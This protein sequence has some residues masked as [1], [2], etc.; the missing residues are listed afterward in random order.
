MLRNPFTPAEIASAPDDFFG[1]TN[2]LSEAKRSLAIGSVSIQ[3]QIGIGKSSLLARTRLEMEGYNSDHTAT[4][5]VAVAHKDI[6]SADDLARAILEDIIEIDERQTKA[7]L[8]IGSLFEIGSSDIYRNFVAGRH[9][10]V[11]LRL[12]EKEYMKQMLA[13]RELLIIAIDEADKCPV[14]IAQL[15]RQITSK[16]QHQGMKGV[17]F[18]LAGV[19]PFYQE[20]LAEDPGIGRFIYKTI[21]LS[22]ME[23][24]DATQLIETKLGLVTAEA[25]KQGTKVNID[26]DIVPRI[27]ALSGGHPHLLQLLGSYLVENENEDPDGIMDAQDL[28]SSLRRICYEDRAQVYDSTLHKLDTAGQLGSFRK[29][30]SIAR[31]KFPTRIL[32]SDALKTVDADTLQWMFDNNIFTVESNGAY[33]LLD[34]FLRIRIMMDVSGEDDRWGQIERRLLMGSWTLPYSKDLDREDEIE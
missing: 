17:R 8:K 32:K 4:T 15:I 12:L 6:R 34:E 11:L 18:L 22:P 26:P 19:S 21:I 27:V 9:T 14:Q 25:V 5:V 13:D 1:R 30:I 24:D 29:L 7:T 2:E 23:D 31:Q 33:R 28:T 3:G 20:M 16:A 10:A